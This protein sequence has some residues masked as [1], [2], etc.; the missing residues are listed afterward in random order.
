MNFH[1]IPFV[2]LQ[3]GFYIIGNMLYLVLSKFSPF[4]KIVHGMNKSKIK[5]LKYWKIHVIDKITVWS[6]GLMNVSGFPIE[7]IIKEAIWMKLKDL[8]GEV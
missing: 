2:S 5:M 8:K 1:P 7:I 6:C 4:K 3:F